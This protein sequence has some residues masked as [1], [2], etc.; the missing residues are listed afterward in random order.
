[1][2]PTPELSDE[3]ILGKIQPTVSM[4]NRILGKNAG[5]AQVRERTVVLTIGRMSVAIP[6][7]GLRTELMTGKIGEI[8]EPGLYE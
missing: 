7:T 8:S 1:L 4:T 5:T 6:S 3:L 2:D